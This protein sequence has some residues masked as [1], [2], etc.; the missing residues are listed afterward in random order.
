VHCTIDPS[1]EPPAAVQNLVVSM[2]VRI[3]YN[4]HGQLLRRVEVTLSW[5]PNTEADLAG[6]RI[7]TR[8][9][10]SVPYDWTDPYEVV[11]AG[12]GET[13]SAMFVDLPPGAHY[14]VVAA[15][16]DDDPP[17]M[18]LPSAE[19]VVDVPAP[20]PPPAGPVNLTVDV[21]VRIEY[22]PGSN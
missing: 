18:G 12:P 7:Y 4:Q 8:T 21:S 9:D 17:W 14:F 20:T 6:Y 11:S 3:D 22:D 1:Q 5:D 13:V 2:A 16:D 10:P 19:V 15:F